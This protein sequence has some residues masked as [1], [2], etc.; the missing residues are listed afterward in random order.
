LL[1]R[2][3]EREKSRYAP[4]LVV[5]D[6]DDLEYCRHRA[7]SLLTSPSWQE[8]NVGV[9]LIGL[10][11]HEEKLSSL[12]H[13]LADPTPA[14]WLQGLFGGDYRQVGFIRR[15]IVAALPHLNRWNREVEAH[16]IKALAD[17]YYEV[18]C[19]AARTIRQFADRLVEREVVCERLLSLLKDRSFEVVI[20]AALAL[21]AVAGDRRATQA[22]LDL[23]EHHYWQVRD[24]A[25]KA[26]TL[27][28]KRGVIHDRRWMVTE[29]SRFILTMTDFR[30]HF[31]IKE[32]YR[33][34]FELCRGMEAKDSQVLGEGPSPA[35]GAVPA[36]ER[37]V[38]SV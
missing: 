21:G 27:L 5:S 34:L 1:E 26:L 11:K 2:T 33:Q 23:R 22:L 36:R 35:A 24:A 31:A 29:I 28:V 14:T 32:S 12:L 7:A 15:N 19:Q 25:L 10:L 3:R 6:L 18:R 8:R 16:V 38:Q 30:S 9:K 17:G 13:L 37:K 20:E 4:Q